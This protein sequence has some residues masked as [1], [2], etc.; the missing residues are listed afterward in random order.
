MYQI[1]LYLNQE[2]HTMASLKSLAKWLS[3]MKKI[4]LPLISLLL[5]LLTGCGIVDHTPT[6]IT[7]EGVTY[8]NG[9]YGDLYPLF[10]QVGDRKSVV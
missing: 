3:G 1:E 9:F 6:T 5:L 8:R 4:V 10:G 2:Y 7:I